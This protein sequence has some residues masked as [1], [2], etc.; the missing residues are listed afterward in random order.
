MST[1][2]RIPASGSH[3][4][5]QRDVSLSSQTGKWLSAPNK[6]PLNW[7]SLKAPAKSN[8]SSASRCEEKQ[9]AFV[10]RQPRK[11]E[12]PTSPLNGCKY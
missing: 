7:P 8:C 10:T 2:N 12:E 4:C 5:V 1:L 11:R 3:A 9:A 6:I